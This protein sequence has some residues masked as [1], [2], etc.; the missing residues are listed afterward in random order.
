VM[1]ANG[2]RVGAGDHR[3]KKPSGGSAR[4]RQRRFNFGVLREVLRLVAGR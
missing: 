3:A 2:N 4:E 1:L